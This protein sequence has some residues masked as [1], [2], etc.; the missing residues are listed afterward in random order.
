MQSSSLNVTCYWV[1]VLNCENGHYYTGYTTHLRRRYREHLAGT[2]KCKYT[3]SFK[4]LAMI[5]CWQVL[6]GKSTAMKI[7]RFIKQL[8][9]QNKENLLLNPDQLTTLFD[10]KPYAFNHSTKD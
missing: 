8:S 10:C 3:R 4:P 6:S 7:E 1:Y 2:A 5:Q 9:R